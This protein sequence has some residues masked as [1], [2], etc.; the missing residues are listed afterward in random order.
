MA[1]KITIE[2][3]AQMVAAGFN[4]MIERFHL[5]DMRFDSMDTRFELIESKIN[6][7]GVEMSQVKTGLNQMAPHFELKQLE[8]RV[9]KIE[10]HVGTT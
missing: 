6:T 2:H 5:V 8:K 10:K 7:L 9:N 4:D 1:R 3:L